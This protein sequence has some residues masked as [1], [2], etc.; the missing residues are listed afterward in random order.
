SKAFAVASLRALTPQ[1]Y[2]VSLVLATGDAT[3]DQAADAAARNRRYRDLEG[4]SARLT[5]SKLLDARSDRFQ[6]SAG[7]ALFMSNH[8]AIQQL[9]AAAGNNLVSRLAAMAD[10]KQMVETAIWTV[11]SRPPEAEEHAFLVRW[12]ED[13]KEDRGKV[14]GQLVW[15]LLTSAEFRFNH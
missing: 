15:A 11:L 1:Q 13:R 8:A 10:N 7:E 12:V 2:A 5:S 6:S 3:F 9:L 4:V 14:C